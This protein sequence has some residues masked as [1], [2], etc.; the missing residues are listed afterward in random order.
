M[1]LRVAN[2]P[3]GAL[4]AVSINDCFWPFSVIESIVFQ[5]TLITALWAEPELSL[6]GGFSL[7][8]STPELR[9]QL[10]YLMK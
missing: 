3:K 7:L 4:I 2:G 1:S 10:F 9:D 8:R 5:A 6:T